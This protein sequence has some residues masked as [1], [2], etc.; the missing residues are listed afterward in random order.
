MKE[1]AEKLREL[2]EEKK[3]SP[4]ELSKKLDELQMYIS[5]NAIRN[6]ENGTFPK[7]TNTFNKLA[8][9]FEVTP[10][11]LFDKN[12]ENKSYTNISIGKETGLEDETIKTIRE[13]NNQNKL[14]FNKFVNTID[15][16]FWK[17]LQLLE[18]IKEYKEIYLELDNIVK[19]LDS[20]HIFKNLKNVSDILF[21]SLEKNKLKLPIALKKELSISPE[22]INIDYYKILGNDNILKFLSNTYNLNNFQELTLLYDILKKKLSLDDILFPEKRPYTYDFKNDKEIYSSFN[23]NK[24]MKDFKFL[25]DNNIL[26]FKELWFELILLFEK[27]NINDLEKRIKYQINEYLILY[28]NL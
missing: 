16:D 3:L 18:F 6:Y 19:I 4:E 5:P 8:D 17:N 24:A 21:E 25:L 20:K 22:E 12:I 28:M 23:D 14:A 15:K 10:N 1:F 7:D 9:F 2:R 26:I 13:I 11:Y 27:H